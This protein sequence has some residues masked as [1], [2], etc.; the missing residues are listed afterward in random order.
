MNLV[1]PTSEAGPP[2][3]ARWVLANGELLLQ[4]NEDRRRVSASRVF[5]CEY[6]GLR[7]W[8]DV[9]VDEPPSVAVPGLVVERA[10]CDLGLDIFVPAAP[11]EAAPFC[12]LHLRCGGSFVPIV[13]MLRPG[14]D[15][16][17]VDERWFAFARADV[18][19]LESALGAALAS[20]GS[21]ITL[22]QVIRLRAASDLSLRWF[23]LSDGA[24]TS[25]EDSDATDWTKVVAVPPFP[26]QSRGMAWLSRLVREDVGGL[27]ADEMGLGKTLQAIGLIAWRRQSSSAPCLVVTPTSLVENWRREFSKFAPHVPVL[28]HQGPTRTG[29]PSVLSATDCVV[30]T[31]DCMVRDEALFQAVSWD[32]VVLDEAQYIKNPRSLRARSAA[33]LPRKVGIAVTGTPLENQLLD[34]WSIYRF[35]IPGLLGSQPAFERMV[36]SDPRASDAVADAV[37]PFMLRRRL[38]DVRRDMPRRREIATAISLDAEQAAIYEK[39]RSEAVGAA[40]RAPSL[41]SLSALR[42]YCGHPW[43]VAPREGDPVERSLKLQRLLDVL[44]VVKRQGE[45]AL[46][47]APFQAL[48]DLLAS[49][50]ARDLGAFARVIDG[51]TPVL[52]RQL[53][54][55]EFSSR[56]GFDVLLLNPRA[57]GVGLN[58]TAANHVI[59]FC[60][61][62][63]PA[64][65]DQATARAH[66]TGQER[67][68]TVHRLYFADTVE[69]VME[70]RLASKRDLIEDVV[71][72]N[73][74]DPLS[75]A[76]IAAALNATPVGR[77]S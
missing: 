30:T 8:D 21:R 46:V 12:R 16:C 52:D 19:A 3:I 2:A 40:G 74:S 11:S 68:V 69:E 57:A 5:A 70:D 42:Q 63:N 45:R 10:L 33:A 27:L 6:R 37:S 44:E 67:E 58:I 51:R 7:E 66:R 35:A 50:L 77:H 60:P 4:V 32:V 49:V 14:V 18:E 1:S 47:F 31:Y 22:A 59:H 73:D 54:I 28:I 41:A 72:D 24:G 65:M 26:Y 29:A 38:G 71:Q 61:E 34:L 64:V 39:V 20:A 13:G 56:E 53:L 55:D 15:H 48:L 17:I 9:K 43:L 36:A 75:P 23:P 25:P 62:W 76:D